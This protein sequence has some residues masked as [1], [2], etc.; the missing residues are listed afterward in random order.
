MDNPRA[1]GTPALARVGV[2]RFV[3]DLRASRTDA[4]AASW[5]AQRRNLKANYETFLTL[6]SGEAFD[7]ILF[8]DTLTPAHKT[9]SR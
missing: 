8:V 6:V 9:P 7:A 4:A 5:L 3:L 1:V 2:P